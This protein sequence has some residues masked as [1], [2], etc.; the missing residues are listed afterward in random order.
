MKY[1]ILAI[2]LIISSLCSGENLKGIIDGKATIYTHEGSQEPFS[3]N[4]IQ[5][6]YHNGRYST[7]ATTDDDGVFYIIIDPKKPLVAGSKI[8]LK[9]ENKNYFI[10]SPFNGEMSAPISTSSYELK[11]SVVSN[12]SVIKTSNLEAEFINRDKN[13]EK[14]LQQYAI[15]ILSTN[16][17]V[18]AL[19]ARDFFRSKQ[20]DS[21]IRKITMKH[22]LILYKVYSSSYSSWQEANNIKKRIRKSFRRKYKD[23]FVRLILK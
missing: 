19:M 11:I 20:Y 7:A 14:Q 22:G 2:F 6:Y 10:L 4:M 18:S 16:N 13:K 5:I 17:H 15:Q 21:F 12:K 9:L 8:K 3:G 23:S 1:L